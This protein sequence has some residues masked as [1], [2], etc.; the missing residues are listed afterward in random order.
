[1]NRAQIVDR[2]R[3][4][5]KD[6]NKSLYGQTFIFVLM[7]FHVRPYH[8]LKAQVQFRESISATSVWLK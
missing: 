8:F 2:Q 4:N 3:E 6:E 1:M 7:N 5:N